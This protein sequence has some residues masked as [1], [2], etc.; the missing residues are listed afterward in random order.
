DIAH[1]LA[2]KRSLVASP[3]IILGMIA[4][5]PHVASF[6][7]AVY[8]E[9]AAWRVPGPN[10]YRVVA[11]SAREGVAC[12]RVD[13]DPLD[14]NCKASVVDSR[15]APLS[16]ARRRGAARAVERARQPPMHRESPGIDPLQPRH[17]LCLLCRR[18]G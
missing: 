6:A 4:L 16:H 9:L 5:G 7:E 1:R 12:S 2:I 15:D 11:A 10:A 3:N 8:V 14:G 13:G 18:V 17:D